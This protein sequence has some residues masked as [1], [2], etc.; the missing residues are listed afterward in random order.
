M[1]GR[2]E[3]GE[4]CAG[5]WAK[6]LLGG[7]NDKGTVSGV[8]VRPGQEPWRRL[9]PLEWGNRR[10]QERDWDRWRLQCGHSGGLQWGLGFPRSPQHVF[11]QLVAT[12]TFAVERQ[13]RDRKFWTI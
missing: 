5:V 12:I 4:G 13:A 9:G 2:E 1:T 8:S 11:D 6:N 7:G 3:E 10:G